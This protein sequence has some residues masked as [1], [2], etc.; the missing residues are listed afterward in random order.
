MIDFSKYPRVKHF[1]EE[2]PGMSLDEALELTEKKLEKEA[3]KRGNR[4]EP[5]NDTPI[6][7]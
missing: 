5:R 7:G 6:S 4:N 2:N 3:L 1:L